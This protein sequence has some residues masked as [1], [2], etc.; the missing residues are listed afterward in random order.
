MLRHRGAVACM[1]SLVLLSV[2]VGTGVSAASNLLQKG[3]YEKKF[4]KKEFMKKGVMKKG[5]M[6]KE[7]KEN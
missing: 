6:K 5:V 3:I 4:M 2:P 7:F 1:L